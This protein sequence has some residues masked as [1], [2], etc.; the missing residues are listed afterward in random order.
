MP[1]T[2][3][4]FDASLKQHD[5]GPGH[6]EQPARLSAAMSRFPRLLMRAAQFRGH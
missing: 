4:A 2:G 5:P 6:P 3:I 1:S